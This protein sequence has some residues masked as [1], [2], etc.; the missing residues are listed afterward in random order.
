MRHYKTTE[1]MDEL[2]A[3]GILTPRLHNG[4]Y[5]IDQNDRC[6]AWYCTPFRKEAYWTFQSTS[7]PYKKDE[8]INAL[9]MT[10]EDLFNYSL[11][12]MNSTDKAKDLM[13]ALK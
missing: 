5:V 3:R 9:P 2:E 12:E 7:L 10:K 8:L 13:N 4:R 6:I 1:I 11:I